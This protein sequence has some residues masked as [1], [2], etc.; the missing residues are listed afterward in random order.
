MLRP[1]TA[2]QTPFELS[3]VEAI[4]A[5]GRA[6]DASN[7]TSLA[8]PLPGEEVI[9]AE[10]AVGPLWLHRN[11]QVMTRYLATGT[12]WEPALS[13]FLQRTLKRGMT[14]VDVG[15]NVGYFSILASQTMGPEGSVIAV[16]PQPGTVDIL[17]ANLWRHG[18]IDALV[19]PVAAYS[20]FGHLELVVNEE[21]RGG[22]VMGPENTGG[23]LIPCA[24]L[25]SLLGGS[26]VDVLKIDA[27][28]CD[29]LIVEGASR[30][31]AANPGLVIVVEFW[32]RVELRN[33]AP[34]DI[35]GLYCDT[36]GFDLRRIQ[37]DGSL[38]PM[39]REEALAHPEDFFELVLVPA[40][41]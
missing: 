41:P 5:A 13:A 35:L 1:Y 21:N 10:T 32:P 15:A 3:L 17:R 29:H 34:T 12:V 25:D 14:F 27:E 11:D 22:T 39:T 28:G 9:E 16:E 38:L 26:A 4:E 18:Y 31:I 33:S 8:I 20:H 40:S 6:V 30:T 2:R 23:T 7:L 36:A 24:P 37:P 19:L